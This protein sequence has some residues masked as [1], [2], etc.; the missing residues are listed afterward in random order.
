MKIVGDRFCVISRTA[1]VPRVSTGHQT[2]SKVVEEFQDGTTWFKMV[3]DEGTV[4]VRRKNDSFTKIKENMTKSNILIRKVC[5]FC[6][7]EFVAGKIT[8]RFC[9]KTCNSRAYKLHQRQL[10][11]GKVENENETPTEDAVEK[12]IL[13][14]NEAAVLL[15]I[16]SRSVY[17][18]IYK[19][20]LKAVKLSSRM[21]LLRKSDIEAMLDS[22]PYIKRHK[23]TATPITEFYTTE[24]VLAK[25]GISNAHLYKV[26][27]TVKLPKMLHRGKTL[28]SKK[29]IDAHFGKKTYDESIT[30]WCTADDMKARF[31]MTNSAVYSFV[32]KFAIPKKKEKGA[33]YYSTRHVEMAK[34]I[35]KQED[36]FYTMKE[37]MEKYGLTR[38]QIYHYCKRFGIPKKQ[39]GK[40]VYISKKGLDDVMKPPSL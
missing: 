24:E 40:Y 30:E 7:K 39:E 20:K 18:L 33:T 10:I 3:L 17:N 28:W 1:T 8:T 29:H 37:A 35:L 23:K 14:P 34:G 32:S 19:G 31:G 11:I 12:S 9:S 15:G 26:E 13:T 22:N 36:V 21:T 38:D 4:T 25:Y 5:E 27:K 2:A 6:G 16:T